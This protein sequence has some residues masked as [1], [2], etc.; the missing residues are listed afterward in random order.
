VNHNEADLLVVGSW[1]EI[2]TLALPVRLMVFVQEQAVPLELECDEFDEQALHALVTDPEGRAIA[3][4]RLL[5]D[6]RIGRLAV[7]SERRSTG[8]GKRVLQALIDRAH[9]QG[10]VRLHLHARVEAQSF[11]EKFGF[12]ARG[13]VFDEAGSPHIEM[14]RENVRSMGGSGCK[15]EE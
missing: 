11:Y 2:R 13:A 14:V 15:S 6:G 5:N 8:V 4:G 9:V 3:T 1:S 12:N 10:M 7:L